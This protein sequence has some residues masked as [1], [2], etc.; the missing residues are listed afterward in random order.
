MFRAV[1]LQRRIESTPQY[2]RKTAA[3]PAATFRSP[4]ALFLQN[5]ESAIEAASVPPRND[6]GLSPCAG[7]DAVRVLV[8]RNGKSKP[9]K[10]TQTGLDS[11]H[12][13]NVWQYPL[14]NSSSGPTEEHSLS[15]INTAV[16]PVALVADAILDSTS[17][18]QIVLDPFL[19]GGSTLIAAERVGR[20]CYG[21]ELNPI[22]CDVAIRRW[23]TLT[24]QTAV[25]GESGQ[26][27]G[28]SV[29]EAHGRQP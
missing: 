1:S 21:I 9:S 22:Y 20:I 2:H 5:F 13:T 15:T 25:H 17:R 23:Q 24:G 10:N 18:G 14:V 3:T 11:R 8:L 28:E 6:V 4:V 26:S 19:G 27:F 12:R 29:E 16:K 7:R